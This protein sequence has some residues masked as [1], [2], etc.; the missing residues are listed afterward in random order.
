MCGGC[1]RGLPAARR[2]S[3]KL[4]L[5]QDRTAVNAGPQQTGRA[6]LLLQ[7][8]AHMLY[9]SPGPQHLRT[10]FVCAEPGKV[11]FLCVLTLYAP[12]Y[13]PDL[14]PCCLRSPD[15]PALL[16]EG[17]SPEN[18]A[19]SA[20]DGWQ[21]SWDKRPSAQMCFKSSL[22]RQDGGGKS[23]GGGGGGNGGSK[24]GADNGQQQQSSDPHDDQQHGSDDQGSNP[25]DKHLKAPTWFAADSLMSSWQDITSKMDP[26]AA[27]APDG[28]SAYCGNVEGYASLSFR[29]GAEWSWTCQRTML[30]LCCMQ[31][32]ASSRESA[33]YEQ[34]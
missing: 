17:Q 9:S 11:L 15:N 22:E 8:E 6:T 25:A 33:R 27:A 21:P 2:L 34:V 24:S 20:P 7:T 1:L 16:P 31:R 23:G 5:S 32:S 28:Q 14:V 12:P 4:L 10:E 19:Q 26:W 18:P 13:V 30:K 29:V 3:I